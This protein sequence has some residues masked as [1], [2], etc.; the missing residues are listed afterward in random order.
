MILLFTRKYGK[1]SVGSNVGD[2]GRSRTALALR[3]FTFGNYQIYE[4]RNYYEL[5]RADA[6]TSYY[7][8]GEDLDRYA[9]AA[10]ALELTEKVVPEGLPQPQVF[11]LLVSYL[12]QLEQRKRKFDT[13]LLAYEVK[14][15]AILGVFP[16]LD[17]CASCGRPVSLSAIKTSVSSL[18]HG[19]QEAAG[20]NDSGAASS[21][22]GKQGPDQMTTAE[23]GQLTPAA[24][25]IKDGGVICTDC[26]ARDGIVNSGESSV[27][28]APNAP[29][30]LIFPISADIITVVKYYARNPIKKLAGV[31][32]SDDVAERLKSLLKA[33]IDYHFDL[34]DLKS[35]SLFG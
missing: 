7:G 29:E 25:S 18:P 4:G 1:I 17:T 27:N 26:A 6:V 3:P 16:E 35:E 30:A 15:L 34:G 20:K 12:E 2:K 8:I 28:F 33:Y 14:L 9:A 24:F 22:A 31:A 23:E 21:A 5:D 13:L 11:D 10:Y 19:Q 32:L